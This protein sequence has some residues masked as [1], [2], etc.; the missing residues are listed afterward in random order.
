MAAAVAMVA[1]RTLRFC[2]RFQPYFM[3]FKLIGTQFVLVL[4]ILFAINKLATPIGR[5]YFPFTPPSQ[6]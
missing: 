3:C 1:V 5:D 2:R 6:G 4:L